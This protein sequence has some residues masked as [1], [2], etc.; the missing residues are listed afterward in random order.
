MNAFKLLVTALLAGLFVY[1]LITALAGFF[2][3]DQDLP[4]Q[5]KKMLNSAE[6]REGQSVHQTFNPQ[7]GDSL[8][9]RNYDTVARSTAFACTEPGLCCPFNQPCTQALRLSP[10]RVVFEQSRQTQATA[11][12]IEEHALYVCKVYF[13]LRPAQVQWQ[14]LEIKKTIDIEAGE[15][16]SFNA[17]AKNTGQMQAEN[18]KVNVHAFIERNTGNQKTFE[19][20]AQGFQE[21]GIL[22]AGAQK[23]VSMSVPLSEN[24]SYKA[25]IQA[26]GSNAGFDEQEF[27]FTAFNGIT[28]SSCIPRKNP[29]FSDPAVFEQ[30]T[31]TC[32]IKKYCEGCQLQFQCLEAIEDTAGPLTGVLDYHYEPGT[33]EY[34]YLVYTPASETC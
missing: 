12:C 15:T 23:N 28:L 18:V 24:G 5:V 21:I 31:G 17:F 34:A 25:L 14:D 3:P 1:L 8:S 10:E 30:S 9:A 13:G 22:E 27:L 11:R 26:E 32:R 20:S 7:T 2:T 4:G 33:S 16:L 19:E 29:P 6:T